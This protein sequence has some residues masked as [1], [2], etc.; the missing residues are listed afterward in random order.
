MF[1]KEKELFLTNT[2]LITPVGEGEGSFN[3]AEQTDEKCWLNAWATANGSFSIVLLTLIRVDE[4]EMKCID[5]GFDFIPEMFR[6]FD[7]MC[8]RFFVVV[9]FCVSGHSC[10]HISQLSVPFP[11]NRVLRF[12]ESGPCFVSLPESAYEI[13]GYPGKMPSLNFSSLQGCMLVYDLLNFR[14]KQVPGI[15]NIWLKARRLFVKSVLKSG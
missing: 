1:L 6:I 8:K 7:F 5:Y 12:S 2:F 15:L 9:G 11:V 10:A 3:T 13:R 14:V 4:V